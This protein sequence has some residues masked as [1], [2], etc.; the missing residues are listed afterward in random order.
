MS[1]LSS[2]TSTFDRPPSS[3]ARQAVVVVLW[4][5]VFLAVQL[6]EVQDQSRKEGLDLELH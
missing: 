3:P 6:L 1:L 5:L 4:T 2:S